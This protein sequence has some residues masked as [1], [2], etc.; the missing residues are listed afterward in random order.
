MKNEKKHID[1]ISPER[2]KEFNRNIRSRLDRN[3]G[4][5]LFFQMLHPRYTRIY[6]EEIA[7]MN[8]I[9]KK[10]GNG[11]NTGV[12]TEI[13]AFLKNVPKDRKPI[14]AKTVED[15]VKH[16]E[17]RTFMREFYIALAGIGS[18]EGRLL[19]TIAELNKAGEIKDRRLRNCRMD[20][21]YIVLHER[22]GSL[23]F[24][25]KSALPAQKLENSL[26]MLDSHQPKHEIP[27]LKN[28]EAFKQIKEVL[29]VHETKAAKAGK[30][31][32]MRIIAERHGVNFDAMQKVAG[33][34]VGV[35]KK[36][37]NPE[38]EISDEAAIMI[39]RKGSARSWYMDF[40]SGKIEGL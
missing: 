4:P 39:V 5:G 27:N 25:L 2:V 33:I 1:H 32:C 7:V 20:S 34:R 18:E 24:G 12:E 17:T 40:R 10:L 30:L 19:A 15:A 36:R 35:E 31:G 14:R 21:I 6:N 37:K 8:D 16:S 22:S 11:V 13:T 23:K 3:G 9:E 26:A 38:K 29:R 28:H